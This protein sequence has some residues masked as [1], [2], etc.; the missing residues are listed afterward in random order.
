MKLCY[1]KP[2]FVLFFYFVSG[3]CFSQEPQ[4]IKFKRESNLVKAVF[5]ITESKLFVID[6]YGNPRENKIASY[7]LYVK[8]RKETKEF[9]GY[10]NSLNAEML[11]YLKKQSKATKIFFTEISALDDDGHHFLS[12][13]FKI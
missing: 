8:A 9:L 4:T 3:S 12:I 13:V 5:D 6:R 11:N 10:S 2:L 1:Y 7:K